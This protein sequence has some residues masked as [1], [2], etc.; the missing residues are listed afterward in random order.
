[1]LRPEDIPAIL[2]P[3]RLSLLAFISSVTRDYHLAED[4]FQEVC[5]KAVAR[6]G[7]FDSSAHLVH[8]ARLTGKNRA[9][10]IMR[11][12]DGRMECLSDNLLSTLAAEWPAQ[13]SSGPLMDALSHC[14][15]QVTPYNRELLRMRY[16]EKRSSSE[17]AM[18]LGR[19]IE[20]VYQALARLHKSLGD[21]VRAR[22]GQ[23]PIR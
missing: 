7:E 17:V 21:C 20:T 2:F 1:M 14:M 23:E 12:R 16:F 5:A 8:W 22:M 15:D 6:A 9:I 19:K 10:D 3:E 11:A 18:A 4:V 13:A